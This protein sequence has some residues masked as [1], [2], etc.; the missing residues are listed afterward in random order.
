MPLLRQRHTALYMPESNAPA[1]KKA[2]NLA[3]FAASAAELARAGKVVSAFDNPANATR[4]V[5]Q[6]DGQMVQRLHLAAVRRDLAA[7]EIER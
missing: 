6:V 5:V 7:A 1:I 4:N 3:A 2:G